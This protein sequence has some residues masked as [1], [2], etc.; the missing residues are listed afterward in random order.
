MATMRCRRSTMA[1]ILKLIGVCRHRTASEAKL[2][3]RALGAVAISLMAIP[4]EDAD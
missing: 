1:P 3:R 2:A 4:S